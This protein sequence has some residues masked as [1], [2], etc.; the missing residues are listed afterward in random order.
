MPSDPNRIVR[1]ISPPGGIDI[2]LWKGIRN[3][4]NPAVTTRQNRVT[5]DPS[6]PVVD[7]RPWTE[8]FYEGQRGYYF[9]INSQLIASY[10]IDIRVPARY[11]GTV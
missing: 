9:I 2:N 5:L 8:K 7:P 3:P 6:V 4:I 10:S 1:S 11:L